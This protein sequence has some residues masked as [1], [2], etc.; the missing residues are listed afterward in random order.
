MTADLIRFENL[1]LEAI[2]LAKTGHEAKA[3]G[4]LD[5]AKDLL[6]LPPVTAAQG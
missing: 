1:L 3:A 2:H 4:C 5:A 6:D